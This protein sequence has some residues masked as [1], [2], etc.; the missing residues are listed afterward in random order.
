[1]KQF[2]KSLTAT[3]TAACIFVFSAVVYG[4][5]YLP[6]NID[7]LS[8]SQGFGNGFFSVDNDILKNAIN[9]LIAGD[10]TV[11]KD[12]LIGKI[13]AKDGDALFTSFA[14]DEGY[15]VTINGK[16][17]K[18]FSLNGFLAIELN[19]GENRIEVGFFPSGLSLGSIIFVLGAMLLV[20]YMI[21]YKKIEEF[22]KFDG[23]FCIVTIGLGAVVLIAIY[24]MPMIVSLLGYII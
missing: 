8:A 14:Y 22:K 17:A 3:L 4:Q 7:V 9:Q 13:T 20:V 12:K 24:L 23:A 18:T 1:M 2:F 16:K 19:C 15:K 10:F 21:F 5:G 11:K 6:D